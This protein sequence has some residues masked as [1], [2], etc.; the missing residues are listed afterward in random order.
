MDYKEVTRCRICNSDRLHKYLDLGKQPLAN[1]LQR[2]RNSRV[3][4]YPLAV[5]FC[6]VCALSQLSIIVE[7]EI[8]Y[9][10]YPYN[11]SVSTTFKNHCREF[12]ETVQKMLSREILKVGDTKGNSDA[13]TFFQ[14]DRSVLDIGANDGCLLEE[15]KRIG[16]SAWG[17]EPDSKLA[18][19]AESKGITMTNAFW[20][21][22][23]AFRIPPVDVIS[24]TN[25]LAH[26]DDLY[27]F[28]DAVR[29]KL[30]KWKNGFFVLEV[31]YLWNLISKNQ[32]DTVYHEHLSYFLFKPLK[33]IL[34]LNGLYPFKV[35]H[36]DIH[37]GSLRVY[38]SHELIPEDGS[39]RDLEKFERDNGLYDLQTYLGYGEKVSSLK[40]ELVGLL[41]NLK[42]KRKKVVGYG[43]SAKGTTLLNYCNIDSTY[44]SKIIDDTPEKQGKF[45]P[46]VGI[47]VVS[48]DHFDT[49]HPDYIA[50][51]SWNFKLEL[52][53]KTK[54]LGAKYI[55][56]IPRVE[57]L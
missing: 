29:H 57:V 53:E 16:F 38:A 4:K 23:N 30:K 42:K 36:H 13:Y 40:K 35:E 27:G 48:R 10:D 8:L 19:K 26:V 46:G 11:S 24:A 1:S 7:P 17:V 51:L 9:K 50:L 3:K 41:K 32:F 33:E 47:P 43:A 5:L 28:L 44:I 37:G 49:T 31:P 54:H 6:D 18:S 20:S 55:T 34:Q 2:K 15:F 45:V 21:Y 52:I 56:P 39:V 14:R 12:A 25:C 22:R